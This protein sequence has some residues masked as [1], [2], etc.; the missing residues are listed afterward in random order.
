[1]ICNKC[2]KA[3]A[4]PGRKGCPR[5][6]EMAANRSRAYQQIRILRGICPRCGKNK[7]RKNRYH[8]MP[9][10]LKISVY[11]KAAYARKKEIARA[12][13]T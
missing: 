8:C 6:L 2:N 13:R 1:M 9:C 11:M 10:S 5:C 4:A 12:R 7:A 3:E